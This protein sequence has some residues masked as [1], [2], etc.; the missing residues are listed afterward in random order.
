MTPI[1]LPR[2]R[3][4]VAAPLL[5]LMLALAACSS[6]GGPTTSST[7]STGTPAASQSGGSGS[8]GGAMVTTAS[9][10]QYG[11]IL[12]D[13]A[14]D[15]LY[16]LTGDSPTKSICA[17]SSFVSV[18][19]PFTTS[20]APRAGSGVTGSKLGTIVRSDGSMQV[21]YGGHPLYRFSGDSQGGQVNGEGVTNFGGTWY[22]LDASGSAVTHAMTSSST[23]SSGGGSG[24]Y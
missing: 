4:A 19:P 12:V 20:G 21:T 23:T 24:N 3:L 1:S 18:W 16:L 6:S 13:A 22:V 17:S 5:G 8:S 15:T 2:H 11:T 14:G 7:S 9:S 10:S